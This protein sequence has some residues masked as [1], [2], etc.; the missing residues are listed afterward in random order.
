MN[1]RLTIAHYI[2]TLAEKYEDRTAIHFRSAFRTFSFTYREIHQRCLRLAN[3]LAQK[4]INKGDRILVWSYNG[5]EYGS[6]LLGCALSGVVAVP[7]DFSS[8]ADFVELIA[9]KVGAKHL[10]HSKRRP[11]P[12]GKL[13][14]IHVEDLDREIADVPI[15]RT[16]FGVRDEDVYEIVYTSGTTSAPKGV[17]ITNKNIVSNIMNS[18][19]VMPLSARHTFLSVLPL[20]H[21]F[22]QVAGF[23]YPLY[24]GCSVTYLYSRKSSAILE[25]L[26]RERVSIMVTV[27]I[28]LQVLRENILREVRAQ[29]KEPLFS[30]MLAVAAHFP[31]FARRILFHRIHSKLG[32]RLGLFITGAAP[33]DPD[34]E[35]F[36]TA[37]GMEVLQGYGLTEASP[38][39][40]LNAP[41]A[42]RAGSTG[43]CLPRQE[44]KLGPDNE[45]W[46]RGGNVTAGYFDNPDENQ[47]RFEGGWYRTGDIGELDRDGFLFIR[48]R[49]KNMIKSA[50]GLNIYPEDIETTLNKTPGIKDS[51]VIGIEEGGDVR[52]HAVLL[53]DKSRQWT[54]EAVR[55]I[56]DS[57]NQRLQPHQQIQGFTIWPHDDFP[58]TNTL[59]IKR[60]PIVDEVRRGKSAAGLIRPASGDRILDLLADLAKRDVRTI[61]P[62]SNL[63]ADLGMDSIARVELAAMLE[64]EFNVDIDESAITAETTVSD[65][66]EI[67]AA[68]RRETL[69]YHFPRWAVRWPARILRVFLQAIA[70]RVPSLFSWT[71]VAGREN[72]NGVKQPVIF[73]ANHISHYD[74]IYIVRALPWR[75]RKIAAAAAADLM[76]EIRPDDPWRRKFVVWR[77]RIVVT[78]LMNAFPF[79]RDV[80]VKRSFEYMGELMDHGWNILLF[81]EGK[82]TTTGEMDH[83]KSGI[84]LLA[85]A[86]Q[87]PV[88][89]IK[90]IGLY[91]IANYERWIPARFGRVRIIFGRPMEADPEADPGV[92]A[93][94]FEDAIRNLS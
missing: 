11:F 23:F 42:N 75:F 55:P 22:E 10:F 82:L 83:F 68:Q 71:T 29:G 15:A 80:H 69:Y 59:K 85:Q 41:T 89:P 90:H 92:L 60:D 38:V 37:L 19:E 9:D 16:D 30:R 86:M 62:D 61:R 17:I 24:N 33:L 14:H 27:P 13:S 26:Q 35:A 28:F 73:I 66:K 36:W 44:I 6:I 77:D 25:A 93:K 74:A 67:I 54:A 34:V 46:I 5:Q 63:V 79:S 18:V 12:H 65:L 20:S 50:A 1:T 72:L 39:V 52:V 81:P 31:R 32:G 2:L 56:I 84:G 43:K 21:M 48:G 40:T 4:G 3:Y 58:R 64:E 87:V 7:I 45:I 76:F 57:T 78:S 94:R 51:C 8:K 88:V 70:F 47:K 49:L 53:M 91:E